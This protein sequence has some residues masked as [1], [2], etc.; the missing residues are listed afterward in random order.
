[1]IRFE[2]LEKN[3]QEA[4]VK[5]ITNYKEYIEQSK[6]AINKVGVEGA[7]YAFIE[8]LRRTPQGR[9]SAD[10]DDQLAECVALI[11]DYRVKNTSPIT[12]TASVVG[13]SLDFEL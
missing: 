10:A 13:N 3:K 5:P 4:T 1:M 12:G 8:A 7:L 6:R 9:K 11:L 2:Y